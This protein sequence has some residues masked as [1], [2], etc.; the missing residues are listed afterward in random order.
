MAVV[1]A[2]SDMYRGSA[3][4]LIAALGQLKPQRKQDLVLM[5]TQSLSTW[6]D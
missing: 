4:K 1:L 2:T 3:P 5:P 6:H